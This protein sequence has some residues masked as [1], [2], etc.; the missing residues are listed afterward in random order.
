MFGGS[1]IDGVT[2]FYFKIVEYKDSV[3]LNPTFVNLTDQQKLQI[4]EGIQ[5]VT[6][7]V[8]VALEQA[9]GRKP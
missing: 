3:A 4:K 9:Q 6:E 7:R 8:R 2:K 1:Q 5:T